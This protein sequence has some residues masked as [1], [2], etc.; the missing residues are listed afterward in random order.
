MSETLR[1][2]TAMVAKFAETNPTDL[3]PHAVIGELGINSM[4]MVELVLRIEQ[5][6]GINLDDDAMNPSATL[7][8]LAQTVSSTSPD[9]V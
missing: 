3:S 4:S 1:D 9:R 5:H 2:V 6:Y 8:E 7:A